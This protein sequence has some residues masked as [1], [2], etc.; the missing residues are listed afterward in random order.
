MSRSTQY[1]RLLRL[2]CTTF[3]AAVIA[4]GPAFGS[5][6]DD[7]DPRSVRGALS[8]AARAAEA[9]DGRALYPVIDQRARDALASIVKDRARAARL[10][11]SDYP[12]PEQAA[13][14]LALGDA[15]DVADPAELFGRRCTAGCVAGLTAKLGA[16][17]SQAMRGD[18]LEV[19]TAQG[20]TLRLHRGQDGRWG[21]PW[22]TAALFAER[23]RAARELVQIHTNAEV[24]RRRRQLELGSSR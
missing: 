4:S 24:Y 20:G 3:I 17:V 23:R 5:G 10:I 12:Q 22:N 14:L 9:H 19:H 18:E 6:C 15:V 7:S 13:A 21:L 2:T 8:V 11:R 16:P 1:S